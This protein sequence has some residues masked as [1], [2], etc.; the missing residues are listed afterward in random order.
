M[1]FPGKPTIQQVV[2][3]VQDRI[4]QPER[5]GAIRNISPVASGVFEIGQAFRQ[6]NWFRINHTN[7][8]AQQVQIAF[9]PV[10]LGQMWRFHHIGARVTG[11]VNV[12]CRVLVEYTAQGDPAGQLSIVLANTFMLL[13]AFQTEDL[14]NG[15]SNTNER[16]FNKGPFFD[17]YPPGRLTLLTNQIADTET[18]SFHFVM[19]ILDGPLQAQYQEVG[20]PLVSQI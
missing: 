9:Q 20:S 17:I 12:N 1:T 5:N 3:N 2:P 4:Q 7:A 11:A 8:G 13:D 18:S 16:Y 15:R 19:E 14:L 10:P 6:L